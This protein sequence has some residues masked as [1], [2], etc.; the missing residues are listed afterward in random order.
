MGLGIVLCGVGTS[1]ACIVGQSNRVTAS[2]PALVQLVVEGVVDLCRA[3]V[4]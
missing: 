2:A 4:L 1:G 3:A